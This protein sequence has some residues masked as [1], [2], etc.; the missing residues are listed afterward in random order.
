M[1]KYF[2]AIILSLA[3]LIVL[4]TVVVSA[5]VRATDGKDAG[6]VTVKHPSKETTVT[7]ATSAADPADGGETVAPP[8][9]S[10]P[11]FAVSHGSLPLEAGKKAFIGYAAYPKELFDPTLFEVKIDNSKS[12]RL[13][14]VTDSVITLFGLSDGNVTVTLY[15]GGEAVK[16]VTVSV[17]GIYTPPTTETSPPETEAPKPETSPPETSPPVHDDRYSLPTLTKS[18]SI[19]PSRPM[20]ALTFD[21]GPGKA[22][23]RLLDTL[24]E[25]G[26]HGTFFI[27]GER[28][29][30]YAESVKRI[31]VE[32]HELG[33]HTWSHKRLT[34]LS[35]TT[36]RYEISKTR[37]KLYSL[38]GVM[39]YIVRPPYGSVNDRVKQASRLDSF[40]IVNWNIDTLDWKLRDADLVYESIMSQAKD[41]AIILLHDMH[42]ESVEAVIRAIPDLI[43]KGYQLVTVSELI[44]YSKNPPKTGKV[45]FYR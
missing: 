4:S 1:K 39:P 11:S 38:T 32:G 26:A 24:R 34:S 21:D 44:A 7:D 42:T 2:S 41:G 45:I 8:Q 18:D 19:D 37:D 14:K 20:L 36:I 22:T 28:I 15:Y 33:I 16:T 27:V 9:S 31:A 35:L 25:Y 29:R 43:D 12:A 5:Y 30:A 17:T 3:V 13:D 6:T 40:Y 10:V 23:P